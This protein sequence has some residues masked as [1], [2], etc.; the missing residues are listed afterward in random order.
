M[1]SSISLHLV[2]QIT[3]HRN[4]NGGDIEWLYTS[5]RDKKTPPLFKVAVAE[6]GYILAVPISA[7]EGV[8]S[9]VALLIQKVASLF[10]NNRERLEKTDEWFDDTLIAIGWAQFNVAFNLLYNDL[11]ED[12]NTVISAFNDESIFKLHQIH[13]Q[14]NP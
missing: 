3:R 9:A 14:N 2:Q 11:I 7:I 8:V 10:F 12:I 1:T 4:V 5:E 13:R 6:V